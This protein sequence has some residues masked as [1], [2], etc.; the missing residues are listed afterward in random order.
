MPTTL[1]RTFSD[2]DKA[3]AARVALLAAGLPTGKVQLTSI[4]DEAGPVEGNFVIGSG[5]PSRDRPPQGA[6][7]GPDVPYDPN[8]SRT[9]SRGT[10]LITVETADEEQ[11]RRA[12]AALEPFGG[13]DVNAVSS[14]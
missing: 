7:T 14:R 6:R 11:H 1:V 13:L 12:L 5:K 3:Q 10:H 4:E 9:I 2:F 8:F